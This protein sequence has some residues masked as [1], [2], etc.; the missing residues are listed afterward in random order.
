MSN[1]SEKNDA[2]T[3]SKDSTDKDSIVNKEN[4]EKTENAQNSAAKQEGVVDPF[5]DVS[6]SKEENN[7]GNGSVAGAA[8]APTLDNMKELL[9]KA[10]E[11][12]TK[13]WD[14]LLRAKAE[15][16]NA[17]RRAERDVENAHKFA[18][19]RFVQELVPV[20]DSMEM[21][22]SAAK[23]QNTSLEKF[24]EGSELTLKMF[25]DCVQKFGVE[26]VNPVGE[27]FNPEFHQ[28]M[29]MQESD[30]HGPNTV[31]AVMQKGYTLQGRLIRPAMVVVSK[32]KAGSKDATSGKEADNGGA[33]AS[34]SAEKSA[35][36]DTKLDQK[37]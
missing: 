7:N 2:V 27:S 18:I 37:A 30:E 34:D 17:R 4:N 1:A 26:S 25:M 31:I 15:L 6:D 13:H 8:K 12:A 36:E 19:E 33:D 3:S 14:E 11:K 21:G 22:I 24:T 32:A 20:I 35:S 10:E 28:A 23:E 5:E 16:E 29:T 9:S